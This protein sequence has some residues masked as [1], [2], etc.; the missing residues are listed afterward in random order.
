MQNL[1]RLL[2]SADQPFADLESALGQQ[3][4]DPGGQHAPVNAQVGKRR[5]D[6]VDDLAADRQAHVSDGVHLDVSDR[7]IR[8]HQAG[9]ALTFDDDRVDNWFKYLPYLDSANVKATFYVCKYNELH[10]K[11]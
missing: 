9:V 2:R 4:G 6:P 11:C 8:V 7:Q 1:T 10:T 5:R 3:L